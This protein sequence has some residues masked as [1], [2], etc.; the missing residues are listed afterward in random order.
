MV[1]RSLHQHPNLDRFWIQ[2]GSILGGFW[3]PSW[4]Q[5][6]TKSLPKSIPRMIKKMITFWM[7]LETDFHQFW[8]PTWPPRGETT[9]QNLEHFSL[10]GPCWPQ[11]PPKIP[12]DP[13]QEASRKGFGTIL[14][15]NFV[16]FVWIS[17]PT[18]LI[19]G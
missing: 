8:L 12:Q 14:A 17:E 9:I 7:A 3:E 4:S 15:S 13:P 6:R 11:D 5:D 10:L 2:L 19:F 16:D 1:P 18:W